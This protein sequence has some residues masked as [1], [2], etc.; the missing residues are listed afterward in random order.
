MKR[1]DT[2]NDVR[3]FNFY[4]NQLVIKKTDETLNLNLKEKHMLY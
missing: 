3:S 2:I 4:K 1:I